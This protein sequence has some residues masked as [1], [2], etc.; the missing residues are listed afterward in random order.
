MS[1]THLVPRVRIEYVKL[2]GT[3][4]QGVAMRSTTGRAGRAWAIIFE[5]SRS[6][7]LR[8]VTAAVVMIVVIACVDLVLVHTAA[9]AFLYI[10][11]LVVIAG[12]LKRWQIVIA[13]VISAVLREAGSP[14]PW[15]DDCITRIALVATAF[16]GAALFVNELARNQQL[17]LESVKELKMRQELERQL[18]HGQRLEA[19]GRLAGGDCARFQ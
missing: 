1:R 16:A 5:Y 18:R 19:I 7:K 8:V 9:L 17:A 11:P 13:A 4:R 2:I 6:N 12:F 10:L 15:S 3:M 14:N